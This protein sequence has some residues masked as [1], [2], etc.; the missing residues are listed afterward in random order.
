M[1][2]KLWDTAEELMAAIE[3]AKREGAAYK[4]SADFAGFIDVK[5]VREPNHRMIVQ[6]SGVLNANEPTDEF[7]YL[8]IGCWEFK[9]HGRLLI[10]GWQWGYEVRR[11]PLGDCYSDARL[12]RWVPLKHLHDPWTLIPILQAKL[13]VEREQRG[14]DSVREIGGSNADASSAEAGSRQTG[15]AQ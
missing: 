3:K 2:W 5:A 8:A 10:L 7:V 6:C 13:A 11:Y 14:N 15:Q 9:A 12:G 4:K 1:T